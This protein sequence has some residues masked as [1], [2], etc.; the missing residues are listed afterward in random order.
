MCAMI[1]APCQL[2]H[3]PA[4]YGRRWPTQLDLLRK[5]TLFLP[6]RARF[7]QKPS[8]GLLAFWSTVKRSPVKLTGAKLS[9]TDSVILTRRSLPPFSK[10]RFIS[11]CG[12]QN[13]HTVWQIAILLVRIL[14][15]HRKF[16]D[17]KLSR[18]AKEVK[19]SSTAA[20]SSSSG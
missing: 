20:A 17:Q 13:T 9:Y 6:Y 12:G 11:F 14:G 16:L 8:S 19:R 2:L 10:L 3:T 15:D 5:C 7:C 1:G 4:A 18:I